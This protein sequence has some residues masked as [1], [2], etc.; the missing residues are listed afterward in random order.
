MQLSKRLLLVLIAAALLAAWF[1]R[2][3]TT[4]AARP[5]AG[6]NIIAFGDSLVS[7]RGA[8]PG[9]D[10]S[11]VLSRRLGRTIV[12]AG[13]SGDTTASALSRLDADVLSRSPR[14][15]I[16]V[17]GGNDLLRRVPREQ[18]LA[19]L[20]EIVE[21]I[22]ERG[23]AVVL[24]GLGVGLFSDPYSHGFQ[25]IARRT[26]SAFVPDVLDGIVG[27]NSRM[28]DSIH[29]NDAGYQIMADRVE[30]VLRDLV[31]SD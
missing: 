17:L 5:T 8:S 14:V 11:S 28:S 24:V 7:G 4:R 3:E 6:T 21:R 19:N 16:V 15:V 9:N 10:F 1:F 25:E 2:T 13:R 23:A 18:T 20:A 22:R 27:D 12:N 26:S 30:P 31:E 29:P